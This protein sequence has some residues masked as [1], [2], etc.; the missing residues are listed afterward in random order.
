[1]RGTA[2]TTAVVACAGA[3]GTTPAATTT[4]C[5]SVYDVGSGLFRLSAAVT[6]TCVG[7]R[8]RRPR[9]ACLTAATSPQFPT[10]GRGGWRSLVLFPRRLCWSGTPMEGGGGAGGSGACWRHRGGAQSCVGPLY[11]GG[12]AEV[13]GS[14]LQTCG[15]HGVKS[16]ESLYRR[17]VSSHDGDVLVMSV[18]SLGAS[19]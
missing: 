10:A 3:R 5:G 9:A 16:D 18:S 14:G 17:S 12:D 7:W 15:T 13:S 1:V 4:A 8:W 2:A 6:A 11:G 19:W